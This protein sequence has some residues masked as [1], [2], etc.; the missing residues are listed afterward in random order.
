VDERLEEGLVTLWE[1]PLSN[2]HFAHGGKD[3]SQECGAP[4][5]ELGLGLGLRLGFEGEG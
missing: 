4:E 3:T 5:M 1:G 2:L